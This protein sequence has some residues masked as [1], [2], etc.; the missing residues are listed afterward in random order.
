MK[1]QFI[2]ADHGTLKWKDAEKDTFVKTWKTAIKNVWD[3]YQVTT[4]NGSP[5]DLELEFEIVRGWCWTENW[6]ITVTRIKKG[7]FRRSS[8][9]IISR[10]VELDSEDLTLTPK[11]HGQSQRGAVHEFG[12]MIG[13]HDEYTGGAHST[14]YASIMHGGRSVKPRH[15]SWLAKWVKSVTEKKTGV[16]GVL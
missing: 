7:G 13:L 8:V 12:H 11:G 16:K 2:F 10:E 14:D 15:M 9:N 6:E 4:V 3:G 1:V 5:V